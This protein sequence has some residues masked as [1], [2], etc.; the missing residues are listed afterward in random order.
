MNYASACILALAAFASPAFAGGEPGPCTP[1]A[2]GATA[3][4]HTDCANAVVAMPQVAE[5]EKTGTCTDHPL[6]RD[7]TLLLYVPPR[8]QFSATLNPLTLLTGRLGANVEWMPLAHHGVQLNAHYMGG[9]WGLGELLAGD[10][11]V[12]GGE[13]AYRYYVGQGHEPLRL[14]ISP[15]A[16]LLR[17]DA[18]ASAAG[19]ASAGASFEAIGGGLDVGAKYTDPKGLTVAAGFGASYLSSTLDVNASTNSASTGK[20]IKF[21]VPLPRLLFEVGYSF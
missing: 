20:L 6:E 17:F 14:Y 13:L 11:Q 19:A 16:D 10:Y 2:A 7:R 1:E 4:P 18:K 21:G 3:Q 9:G 15:H 12:Y 8:K 5:C